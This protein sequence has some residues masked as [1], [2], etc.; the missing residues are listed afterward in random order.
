MPLTV[1][2]C[3]S[4]RFGDIFTAV[5]AVRAGEEHRYN[6]LAPQDLFGGVIKAEAKKNH[7]QARIGVK[8]TRNLLQ[9][10]DFDHVCRVHRNRGALDPAGLFRGRTRRQSVGTCTSLRRRCTR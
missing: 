1:L 3:P 5:Q 2:G 6:Y 8:K 9:V 10:T 4:L 7:R